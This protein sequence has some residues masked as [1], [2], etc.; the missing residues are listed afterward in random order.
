MS[1]NA[2]GG[3]PGPYIKWFLKKLE[4]AGLYKMA[5]AFEDTSA[6]AQCTFSY[7]YSST[8]PP[9]QFV[10][11]CPGKIV[12]PRGPKNFGWDPCFQPDGYSETFAE[13]S[14]ET[15]NKISHRANAIAKMKEHF[16]NNE[17]EANKM[18][19]KD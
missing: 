13:M 15:K 18:L 4:P 3:L 17:R 10:G 16:L 8:E 2:Y 1:F 11:T 19:K 6:Y 7:M 14:S 9:I 5:N 12:E